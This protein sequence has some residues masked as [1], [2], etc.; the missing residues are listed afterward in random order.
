MHWLDA[1]IRAK[2]SFRT[3]FATPAGGQEPLGNGNQEFNCETQEYK[4]VKYAMLY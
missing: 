4:G 2:V 1:D 3:L